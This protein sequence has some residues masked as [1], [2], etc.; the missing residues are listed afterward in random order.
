M[1]EGEVQA[2]ETVKTPQIFSV[3][4]IVIEPEKKEEG[5]K[6][7]KETKKEE[8]EV[9]VEKE[10]KISSDKSEV[11]RLRQKVDELQSDLLKVSLKKDEPKKE[12]EKKEKLTRAQLVQL[13]TE[14]K[15]N[16]EVLLNIIDYV[17]EQ[18]AEA[19]RDT[20]LEDVNKR[21]WHSS[22]SG[23]QNRLLA[24]DEDGYLAANPGVKNKLTEYAQNLGLGDH[25]LGQ[26]AAYGIHRLSEAIKAKADAKKGEE[27]KEGGETENKDKGKMDRT[28]LGALRSK[29]HGL[30]QEQLAMA[31]KFGVKAETY[32]K[33][34][35]PVKGAV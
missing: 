18:K 2:T 7:T 6:E 25:P 20:T 32:A 11:E 13:F 35:V 5:E 21:Q 23:M 24:E 9:V 3:D 26:L 8:E 30:T 34:V 17:S 16:P 14:H 28:R 12:G 31:K 10:T 15:D 29:E 33:F 19:I 27:T 4:D 22:L 1:A